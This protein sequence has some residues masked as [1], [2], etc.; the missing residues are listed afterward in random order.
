MAFRDDDAA[1][2]HNDEAAP[3]PPPADWAQQ[4][5]HFWFAAH[6]QSHWFRGGPEF[7][8]QIADLAGEWLPALRILPASTFL[9]DEDSALAATILF[10]QVP[11]NL[12]R[13]SAQAF[14]TDT[15]AVAIARGITAKGWDQGWDKNRR[16]FAYLPFEHSEDM[17]D[18]RESMRL[19]S[20][21]NDPTLMDFAQK[22][23]DIVARFG[24]FPH[25]ND[26]LGRKSFPEEADAIA[27]GKNW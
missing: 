26:V 21:L 27:A 4:L 9:T 24:R 1:A 25:R 17:N 22:H 6:D 10:D 8:Q 5:L 11:R 18:Q 12:Y 13:G 20:Q 16:L 3:P 7:D 23:Y 19:F 14:A 15:L 2:D